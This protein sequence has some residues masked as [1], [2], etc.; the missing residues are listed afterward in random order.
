MKDPLFN[1]KDNIKPLSREDLNPF[2]KP[3]VQENIEK[4]K[5]FET[6]GSFE[7]TPSFHNT[8]TFE[9]TPTFAFGFDSSLKSKRSNSQTSGF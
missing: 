6:N 7:N 8:P 9:G 5:K 2:K 4:M 1:D 3:Q